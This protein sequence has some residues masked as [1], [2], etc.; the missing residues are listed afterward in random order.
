MRPVDADYLL[1]NEE[2]FGRAYTVTVLDSA[3]KNA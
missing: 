2:F 1:R 3:K